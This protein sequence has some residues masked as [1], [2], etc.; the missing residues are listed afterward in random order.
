MRFRRVRRSRRFETSR[1]PRFERLEDRAL[2]T[3]AHVYQRFDGAISAAGGEQRFTYRLDADFF[4]PSGQPV[5]LG[6]HVQANPASPLN[7]AA[8]QINRVGGPVVT[9]DHIAPDLA[10]GRESLVLGELSPGEY[11]LVVR[12][13]GGTIGGFA[14]DLFLAGDVDGNQALNRGDLAELIRSFGS[15]T[16][17]AEYRVEADGNL[18]GRVGLK[19]LSFLQRNFGA[20]IQ[21]AQI[22]QISPADGEEHVNLARETIV[23]FSERIDPGTITPDSFHLIAKGERISG[24]VLVSSTER[25]ATFFYDTALPASTEVRVVVDGN[26]IRGRDGALLDADGDGV[27]GGVA[28]ADFRTLPLTRIPGTNIFGYV[29]D[30]YHANPDGSNIPVVGATIR[31]DAFPET[32]ATTDED[33]YFILR[34]MPAPEFFVHIDGTTAINAPPGTIYPSVGKPFHTVP[35]QEI[36]LNMMGVPFNVYLP[37]M[38]TA[39]V[40]TLSPTEDTPVGFGE[41]GLE[42]LEAMF[43]EL[44]ASVWDRLRVTF[45]AGSAVD[46]QGNPATQ[47]VVIPVP[48]DRIPAP[49][50]PFVDP[51]L[52]I[53]IQAI[54]AENFDVPAPVTFPNLDGLAP[55]EKALILSFDHDAGRWKS[56]GSGTVSDNGLTIVSDPGVGVLA[57]GWHFTDPST[58]M[59]DGSC[60]GG[61]GGSSSPPAPSPSRAAPSPTMESPVPKLMVNEPTEV[62][63]DLSWGNPSGGGC[64]SGG[65][66]PSSG[67]LPVGAL[68]VKIEIDGP[69]ADFMKKTGDQPINAN[70]EFTLVDPSREHKTFRATAKSFVEMFGTNGL[71]N[72]N[73][74]RLYGAKVKVTEEKTVDDGMGGTETETTIKTFYAYRWVAAVFPDGGDVAA[75]FRTLDEGITDSF[76]RT[77]NVDMFLPA[78]FATKFEI[79]GFSDFEVENEK[80]GPGLVVWKF[81]PDDDGEFTDPIT[82]KAEDVTIGTLTAKA[83]GTSPTELNVNLSDNVP[84]ADGFKDE[85]RD[86]IMKLKKAVVPGPDNKPGVCQVDDDG[87]NGVDDFGESADG[88]GD[89]TEEIIYE[90]EPSVITAGGRSV[91]GPAGLQ[92][93]TRGADGM[94]GTCDDDFYKK[95]FVI[96]SQAFKNE[97]Q[98]F[99]PGDTFTTGQL[100]TKVDSVADQLLA[101]VKADF[102][103]V[104]V[105]AGVTGFDTVDSS[106]DD[107]DVKYQD[108]PLGGFQTYGIGGFDVRTDPG[109]VQPPESVVLF[110][111]GND[112]NNKFEMVVKNPALSPAA[113]QWQFAEE[114]NTRPDQVVTVAVAINIGFCAP[115]PLTSPPLTPP[116]TPPTNCPLTFAQT[117]A[118]AASHEIGHSFGLKEAYVDPGV[119]GPGI[120]TTNMPPNDLMRS[121]DPLDPDLVFGTTNIA[122]LQAALGMHANADLPLTN[123]LQIFRT[124]MNFANRTFSFRS[125]K[126]S[127]SPGLQLYFEGADVLP[128]EVIDAA[129]VAADGPGGSLVTQQFTLSNSGSLALAIGSISLANGTSGFAITNAPTNGTTIAAGESGLV[130]IAFD[131]VTLGNGS[132]NLIITSD[133]LGVSPYSV[134]VTGQG[135]A[136]SPTA[137]VDR[138]SSNNFGGVSLSQV[139]QSRGDVLRIINHGAQSLV[140]SDIRAVE[141]ANE[142]GLLGW[143]GTPVSLGFDESLSLG[144]TY[145][146][147]ALGFQRGVFEVTTNDPSQPT[148]RIGAMGTGVADTGAGAAA[149]GNDFVAV[150][151]E[152]NPAV[153]TVSDQR[154]G[155]SFLLPPS[156]PYH[157][158]IYDPITDLVANGNGTTA[159]AGRRGSLTSTLV[160]RPSESPDSDFDGLPDDVEFAIGSGLALADT[161]GDGIDDFAEIAQGLSPLDSRAFITGIIANLDLPGT[162]AEIVISDDVA[163]VAMDDRGLAVVDISRFDNPILLGQLGLPGRAVDVDVDPVLQ[164]AAVAGLSELHLV[165][166]SDPMLP[167]LRESLSLRAL[168]VEV[169]GGIAY[170]AEDFFTSMG[171]RGRIVAVDLLTGEEL[172]IAVIDAVA[173]M[174]RDATTLYAV[175]D[176]IDPIGGK[177]TVIDISQAELPQVVDQSPVLLST[178][179]RVTDAFAAQGALYLAT[180]NGALSPRGVKLVNLSNPALPPGQRSLIGDNAYNGVALNGS[181]SVLTT[182]A[183]GLSIYRFVPP[184]DALPLVVRVQT[185]ASARQVTIASGIAFVADARGFVAVNFLSFD[186]QGQAPT[187]SITTPVADVDMAIQGV[188]VVE[189]TTIPIR[190]DVMDDVQVG[191][192]ELLLNGNVVQSDVSFPFD[193]FA[194]AIDAGNGT[195]T[196]VVRA[197]DTGGNSAQSAPL[198]LGVV[199]D[200]V[201]PAIL[202]TDPAAGAMFAQE[203]GRQTVRILFSESLAAQSATPAN[204]RLRDGSGNVILPL[205][206]QLRSNDR[207]VQATFPIFG[208]GQHQIIIRSS[209]I[210]D[211]A[212]NRLGST[213]QTSEFFVNADTTA[214]TI[215]RVDPADGSVLAEGLSLIEVEFSEPMDAATLSRVTIELRTSTGVAVNAITFQRLDDDRLVRLSYSPLA[216]GDYELRL[217]AP[218]IRDRAGLALGAAPL[219]RRFTLRARATSLFSGQ[220][221]PTGFNPSEL[222]AGDINGDSIP[223]VVTLSFENISVLLG[224]GDG[225]LGFHTEFP[226]GTSVGA[227]A[228]ALADVDRDGAL[229]VVVVGRG[230]NGSVLRGRG[231]GTFAAPQVFAVGGG[232]ETMALG[233][234]DADGDLDIVI[235]SY[236]DAVGVSVLL[237]NGDGTFNPRTRVHIGRDIRSVALGNVD[238]DSDLDIVAASAYSNSRNLVFLPGN[239]DGTFGAAVQT[240]L[241]HGPSS[242]ALGDLDADGDLDVAVAGFYCTGQSEGCASIFFGNG[243]GEFPGR[244]NYAVPGTPLDLAMNDID[245][246]GDV[247]LVLAAQQ[248]ISVLYGFGDGAFGQR[249][250]YAAGFAEAVAVADLDRD[251]HM[252]VL[253]SD[254]SIHAVG[255]LPGIGDGEFVNEPG[256]I[257]PHG[258]SRAPLALGDIDA[259]GDLDAV[260]QFLS[261]PN[262]VSIVPNDGTGLRPHEFLLDRSTLGVAVGDVNGDGRPDLV[263]GRNFGENHVLSV[264]LG[265]ADGRF[266]GPTDLVFETNILAIRFQQI[267]LGDVDGD[268]DLDVTTAQYFNGGGGSLAVLLGDGG[269]RF[270][271]PV[272]HLV[273]TARVA[274]AVADVDGD[275]RLDIV[276]RNESDL[277]FL[278]GN[279]DGTFAAPTVFGSLGS[280]HFMKLGKFDADDDLDIVT[281]SFDNLFVF[282][283]NGDGTFA[284]PQFGGSVPFGA[285]VEAGDIDGDS[286]LDLVLNSYGANVPLLINNG[287]GVFS[288]TD[289]SLSGGL[290]AALVKLGDMDADSDLDLVVADTNYQRNLVRVLLG[291]DDATFSPQADVTGLSSAQTLVLAD[292]DNSG[293]PDVLATSFDRF[294]VLPG[295]SGGQLEAQRTELRLGMVPK[296]VVLADFD[297]DSDLDLAIAGYQSNSQVA[298]LLG[299]GNGRFGARADYPLAAR[300]EKLAAGDLDRDGDLDL[301]AVGSYSFDGPSPL[302][303]FLGR[304]DGSFDNETE[305]PV[306]NPTTIRPE[307]ALGDL[308]GDGDLDL[309]VAAQ[310]QT[311]PGISVLLGSSGSTFTQGSEFVV[312]GFRNPEF[313]M[314]DLNGDGRLDIV[315]SLGGT[316]VIVRIGNGD[317][318]FGAATQFAVG[319]GAEK[320]ALAD[321]DGDGDLDIVTA[322]SSGG[323]ATILRGAGDGTFANRID[324]SMQGSP[325]TVVSADIDRDGDLDLI[326]TGAASG[327]AG[328]DLVSVRLN[329]RI[330]SGSSPTEDGVIGADFVAPAP[331]A[332]P[333]IP[334]DV[335]YVDEALAAGS[336][337]EFRRLRVHE[338]A[339]GRTGGAVTTEPATDFGRKL[340]ASRHRRGLVPGSAADHDAR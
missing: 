78:G 337:G 4:S 34:D 262:G 284:A 62:F 125:Q 331:P 59:D 158:A 225:T 156:R 243:T 260:M 293:T 111:D 310:T 195:T 172:G 118:N 227:D 60:S 298:V 133:A 171:R 69:L 94:S 122:T 253:T 281:S 242:L 83:T 91:I 216:A 106:T 209:A 30:S 317:G 288:R 103:A 234:V 179:E 250:E 146:A 57:P 241:D 340:R 286:D 173:A 8:V 19:D 16:G 197:I 199:P 309:L 64:G 233:D 1:A 73:R 290:V 20:L 264:R 194:P 255:V 232:G 230:Q 168:G 27:A 256:L 307:I 278:R 319:S 100:N 296:A 334:P 316:F 325:Q 23:R 226:I 87:M 231:D 201:P 10:G 258:A 104:N 67:P 217:N 5:L 294:A 186:S 335:R 271:P 102:D 292:V 96:A 229:D 98:G 93:L 134:V 50:P 169:A 9:P 123:A 53:S 191:R 161:D 138:I 37:P 2:L 159:R 54:G 110:G 65:G 297:S 3:A 45:P 210:T 333:A 38:A 90:Y 40:V 237:G 265:R 97:F 124:N 157:I 128:G 147:S 192:V 43:P 306:A 66:P 252:D 174:T 214:P 35:G 239:G 285:R 85:L 71:A 238:G 269:G 24:R 277:S 282:P 259:D 113:K 280:T 13:E 155:L 332:L 220:V 99:L 175:S 244:A 180:T 313:V 121:G 58:E 203:E 299:E 248:H 267:V 154:G 283:G 119:L 143:S 79:G 21:P 114:I 295:S 72:I 181:G 7:P 52:V 254:R 108:I 314:G 82:I 320:P 318:T 312:G 279:G 321:F 245:A 74:D 61:S 272:T 84:G 75:F 218:S 190:V 107:V 130:E 135:I 204:F 150:E 263:S 129:I 336:I 42:E 322:N 132:D 22:T 235:G 184:P 224:F 32:N 251:G 33:G 167:V 149:I 257:V 145:D 144:F 266:D 17:A 25:F 80:M 215:V 324:L 39:D 86:V 249:R 36:Q 18:D 44:D 212:G 326:F 177:V 302:S 202:S 77:K 126:E 327:S 240:P 206:V 109:P 185:P 274:I 115:V 182:G 170:V 330:V 275:T 165:D 41:A 139:A 47:A 305:I 76:V 26:Q 270:A 222:A 183:P 178:D 29:Y 287:M 28:T 31:V 140:I 14:L 152:G 92:F 200:T 137:I 160:Y 116:P 323:G 247:D 338:R 189:G 223:D 228:I 308:N 315:V 6:L 219:V 221:F 162:P 117:I 236:S 246:D 276:S 289:I 304:G 49:L 11:E 136:A 68:H 127:S 163:Y 311:G 261:F 301:V 151:V 188:Q 81:D 70:S 268:G 339:S 211:R 196:F 88:V 176:D 105:T 329:R 207:V 148:L 141:G 300:A 56:I 15:T 153:R 213:N 164:I 51:K 112:V 12:G 101:A 291:N 328:F 166:V 55:G 205:N 131:P 95:G 208:A 120:P 142:F 46:N 187:V 198:V 48:P 89:D 303:V 63:P 273:G 193:F